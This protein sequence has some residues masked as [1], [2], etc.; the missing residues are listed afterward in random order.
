MSQ[1]DGYYPR[2]NAGMISSGQ[3]QEMIVS[4]VG[5]VQPGGSATAVDFS[6]A[7]GGAIQLDTSHVEGGLVLQDPNM[8]VEVIGQVSGPNQVTV[9][10]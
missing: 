5:T 8:V 7:D 4:V 6:T 2:L 9:R 1:P 10:M 3:F